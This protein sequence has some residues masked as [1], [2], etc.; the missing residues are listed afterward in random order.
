MS[1]RLQSEST[2]PPEQAR[3]GYRE[4][5]EILAESG[6]DLLMLEMIRDRDQASYAIEAAVSTGLPVW[7]GF[8]CKLS[9]DR[10]QLL[11][12]ND[13]ND[14]FGEALD[15]LMAIGGS[16]VSVMHT[17]V[18]DTA[19]ALEVVRERWN[20]PVGAYP[21]SET[22]VDVEQAALAGGPRL[23]GGPLT[24]HYLL[25]TPS[26]ALAIGKEND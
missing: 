19:P 16:L 2:I 7:V 10:A 1:P 11:L 25:S 23:A 3:A 18:E 21:H 8:S 14:K 6:V 20:G 15:S 4:Q 17:E 22:F 9:D 26:K 12:L 5:A 13:G 24:G